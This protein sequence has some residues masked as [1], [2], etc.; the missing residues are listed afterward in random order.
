MSNIC[1][2]HLG[3]KAGWHSVHGT[4]CSAKDLD[5]FKGTVDI[6]TLRVCD[7]S[8]T[9]D[10]SKTVYNC[11]SYNASISETGWYMWVNRQAH[12]PEQFI[13]SMS[14]GPS[15]LFLQSSLV[16]GLVS[17]CPN[18]DWIDLKTQFVYPTKFAALNKP[19]VCKCSRCL[20]NL[21]HRCRVGKSTREI[22]NSSSAPEFKELKGLLTQG[23]SKRQ[24]VLQK[25]TSH[26]WE[27]IREQHECLQ[28]FQL[29]TPLH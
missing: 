21:I 16:P 9:T 22:Y 12:S 3:K 19:A 20:P 8:T 14:T 29:G 25:H 27:Q 11:W 24:W 5:L 26:R 4:Q 13:K 2:L 7:K 17:G 1:G 18:V 15:H 23:D 6:T 10:L 28:K